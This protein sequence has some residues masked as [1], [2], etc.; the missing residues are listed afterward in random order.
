MAQPQEK[1]S[2]GSVLGPLFFFVLC[3]IGIHDTLVCPCMMFADDTKRAVERLH[4]SH[5]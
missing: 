4:M 1:K 3:I 2:Q 5:T